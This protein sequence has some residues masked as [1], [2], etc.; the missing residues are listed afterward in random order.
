MARAN[1]QTPDRPT[2]PNT[3]SGP[4]PSGSTRKAFERDRRE[5]KGGET[6]LGDRHAQGT[7]GGGTAFGGLGGTNINEGSPNNADLEAAMGCGIEDG[8]NE[9]SS[10]PYAGPSGGA[11]GGTPAEDRSTGGKIHRGLAPGGTHRG[12]STIGS[13]PDKVAE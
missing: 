11:V 6:Q 13:D 8:D 4:I 2:T 12:D 9:E 10:P 3:R 1:K 5:S 7:P